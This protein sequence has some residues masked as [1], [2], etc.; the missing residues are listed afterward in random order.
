MTAKT[1]EAAT[2]FID[3]IRD[4]ACAGSVRGAL[5]AIDGVDGVTLDAQ[6]RFV[7]LRFDP[8]RVKPAQ[9]RTAVRVV[10]CRVTSIV[11]AG[12][13]EQTEI[14]DPVPQ[15]LRALR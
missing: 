9:F 1:M 5:E 4:Q 12:D 7:T 6:G 14:P 10:G 15:L 8:C 2:L 3:A 13:D 11:L